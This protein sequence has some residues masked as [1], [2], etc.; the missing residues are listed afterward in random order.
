MLNRMLILPGMS[1]VALL[2]MA[3]CRPTKLLAVPVPRG[4][5]F[6]GRGKTVIRT[7]LVGGRAP[8]K[9]HKLVRADSVD[10]T[11]C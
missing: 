9:V 11:N 8:G 4:P 1:G 10:S 2:R 3:F 5:P 7:W 6:I